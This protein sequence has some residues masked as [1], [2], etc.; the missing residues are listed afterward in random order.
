MLARLGLLLA[1]GALMAGQAAHAVLR[2]VLGFSWLWLKRVLGIVL[3]LVVLFEEWGWRPLAEW[4]GQLRRLRLVA[5]LEGWIQTLPPYGALAAF[6]L[7]SLLL[8]PLKLIGLYLIANGQKLAAIGL[9]AFAKI[10]G[11]AI[12]AR[13]FILTSPQLMRIGWFARGYG[14]VMP[15][16]DSVYA[17]IRASW[18]WRYGRMLKAKVKQ[19]ARRIWTRWRPQATRLVS[20]ARFQVRTWLQRMRG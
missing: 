6:I 8:L 13:L 9:I 5:R 1:V 15:W 10:T 19:I 12:V 17:Q 7:P 18:A 16:K 11:T 4:L 2:A 3:A 14:I 20:I